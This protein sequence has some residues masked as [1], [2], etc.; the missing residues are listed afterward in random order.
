MVLML[1]L[2]NSVVRHLAIQAARCDYRN[3]TFEVDPCFQHSLAGGDFAPG[4]LCLIGTVDS[5]LP[6]AVVP[7]AGSFQYRR[8][9]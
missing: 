7:P 3:L 2:D 1:I 9:A 6:F 4:R 8:T 5:H